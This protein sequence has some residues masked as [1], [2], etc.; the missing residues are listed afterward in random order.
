MIIHSLRQ[1]SPS[2]GKSA[3]D[4]LLLDERFLPTPVAVTRLVSQYAS[5]EL[6][7]NATK[8]RRENQEPSNFLNKPH[9]QEH[10]KKACQL[11]RAVIA[12]IGREKAIEGMMH[13]QTLF[14][15]C[16]WASAANELEGKLIMMEARK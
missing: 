8:Q 11:I 14:P 10:A 12:G 5:A 1:Q 16:G 15:N 9:E 13:M 2:S 3:I 4:K 7:K 6:E